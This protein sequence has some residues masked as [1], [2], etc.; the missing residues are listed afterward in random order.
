MTFDGAVVREQ[1]VTFG[2]AVVRQSVIRDTNTAGKVIAEFEM[3][4]GVSPVVLMAQNSRG[5]PNYHGR[6]DVVNFLTSIDFRRI[7]WKKYT[8]S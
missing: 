4:M 7:P 3:F 8:Y 6:R 1:G 5:V 2:I